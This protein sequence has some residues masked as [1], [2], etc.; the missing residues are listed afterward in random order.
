MSGTDPT[1]V[2]VP[3]D[4]PISHGDLAGREGDAHCKPVNGPHTDRR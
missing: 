4:G 2:T 1:F 3:D